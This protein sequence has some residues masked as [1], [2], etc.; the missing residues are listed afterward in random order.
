MKDFWAACLSGPFK[1]GTTWKNEWFN[2]EKWNQCYWAHVI[3][4][5]KLTKGHPARCKNGVNF[6]I[7][8]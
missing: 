1:N 8:L 4:L 5:E 7:K 2:L 6:Y 3:M